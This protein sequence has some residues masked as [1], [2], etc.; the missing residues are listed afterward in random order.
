[1]AASKF[2]TSAKM[3]SGFG[4]SKLPWTPAALTLTAGTQAGLV[5]GT[6]GHMSPEQIRGESMDPRSN[7]FSSGVVLYEM[8]AG[9]HAF[10]GKSGAETL[11]A[12]LLEANSRLREILR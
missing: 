5:L 9:Q 6:A 4:G 2:S 11:A 8:L 10:L 3:F 1:M 7:I 12:V